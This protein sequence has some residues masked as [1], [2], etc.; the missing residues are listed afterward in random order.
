VLALPDGFAAVTETGV[1]SR[2]DAAGELGWRYDLQ[3]QVSAPMALLDGEIVIATR[4][5]KVVSLSR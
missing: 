3:E 2:F 4:R 5:G 1:V